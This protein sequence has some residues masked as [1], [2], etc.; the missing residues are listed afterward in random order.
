[1]EE[2]LKPVVVSDYYIAQISNGLKRYFRKYIFDEIFLIL[3]DNTI[4]NTNDEIV[5]AINSGHLYYEY[6]AFRTDNRYPNAVS[7]SLE[8]LGAK[9]KNGAYYIERGKLPINIEQAL[10]VKAAKDAAKL[11]LLDSFLL[12]LPQKL[13][14]ISLKD[15]ISTAV[16]KTFKKLNKDITEAAK[17]KKVPTIG[18]TPS[19]KQDKKITHDY[20]DNM[21]YWVKKWEA[22]NISKMREDVAKIVTDGARIPTI[23]KYFETRWGIA[24]NK[25]KFLA[26]NES[27][28]AGSVIQAT[29]YQDM[30]FTHF[31]W[32]RSSSR[33]KRKLHEEYYGKTFAY[34]DPP[35]IDEKLGQKGLPRQIWNCKCHIM[36][37]L[38]SSFFE[39]SK[40]IENAKR[41][42]FTKIKF[43][44]QNSKQRNNS[45]W[46][47]R[48][49]GEGQ[50][51]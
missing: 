19:E 1:M 46:R 42:I 49:F 7:A 28:L 48:R 21:E 11:S 25:A 30:G 13:A 47:Y 27:H 17:E 33:E 29:R 14:K 44:I 16:E 38:N 43:K 8:N 39:N 32:G 6:G 4:Y 18:F 34:S 15:F 51:I 31:K 23:Q 35:I 3:E 20:V 24:E 2:T 36:P 37:V 12:G 41:N 9:F 22:K 10:S 40:R 45:T 5:N 26:V 50:T